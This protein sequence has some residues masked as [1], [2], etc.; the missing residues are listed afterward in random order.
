M[1]PT[2]CGSKAPVPPPA[3]HR[4]QE[5]V[6]PALHLDALTLITRLHLL[7]VC[8]LA[9]RLARSRCPHRYQRDPADVRR[10]T[11]RNRC[12]CSPF[13]ARCGACPIRICT[14]G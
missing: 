12:C 5:K 2:P 8:R 14:I 6:G 10:S 1:V 3:Y 11:P 7:A 9:V 4:A 13:C